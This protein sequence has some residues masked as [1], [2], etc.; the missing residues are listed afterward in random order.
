MGAA[1][2]LAVL[3]RSPL[4]RLAARARVTL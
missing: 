2:V 4:A 3:L 1:C